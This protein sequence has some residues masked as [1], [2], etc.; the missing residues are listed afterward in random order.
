MGF[1]TLVTVHPIS[2]GLIAVEYGISEGTSKIDGTEVSSALAIAS[3]Y[4]N[5]IFRV[6]PLIILLS[7]V[8]EIPV[9]SDSCFLDISFNPINVMSFSFF[10]SIPPVSGVRISYK[11][12]TRYTRIGQYM[13]GSTMAS[14][15]GIILKNL[16]SRESHDST[17]YYMGELYLQ[18]KRLGHWSQDYMHAFI[19]TLELEPQYDEQKLRN[20]VKLINAD[21]A[22]SIPGSDY[23]IEYPLE[24]L[25]CDLVWLYQMEAL[26]QGAV[27]NG[28]IGI[29]V[30]TDRQHLR[31][32]EIP[33]SC[34][35]KDVLTLCRPL[36][37]KAHKDFY[38]NV[39]IRDLYYTEGSFTIGEP[40][41]L[42]DILK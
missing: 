15:N 39:K 29:L 10:T 3:M 35:G 28:K 19:D 18:E 4:L 17:P 30:S 8:I 26:Y 32:W 12:S 37:E 40:I 22:I 16:E 5:F 27:E 31:A 34:A 36:L 23:S 7:V 2:P 1:S 33:P 13:K 25:M 9:T 38:K 21:K 6:S 24:S 11:Y 20:A 41:Q 14:I 42:N